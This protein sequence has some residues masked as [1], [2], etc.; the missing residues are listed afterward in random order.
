[1]SKI[2]NLRQ[3]RKAVQRTARKKQANQNAVKF[4]RSKAEKEL[5]LARTEKQQRDLSDHKR[6]P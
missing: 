1:M 5:E 6:E 2:V 3:A 4:G